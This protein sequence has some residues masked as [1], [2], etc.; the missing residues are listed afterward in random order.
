MNSNGDTGGGD[1][2]E[3]G[4]GGGVMVKTEDNSVIYD[5]FSPRGTAHFTKTKAKN[6]IGNTQAFQN[7]Q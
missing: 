1:F 3:S 7:M 2:L 4:L 5:K 6:S